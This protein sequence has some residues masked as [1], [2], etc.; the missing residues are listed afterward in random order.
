[1]KHVVSFNINKEEFDR[2]NRLLAIPS[3]SEMSDRDLIAAGANTDQ[4][5]GVLYVA[6]DDGS[7]L[8][9]DLCS[10]QE[11]YFDDVVWT[12]PDGRLDVCLECAFELSDIEFE[13]MGEEYV[14]KLNII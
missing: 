2:I 8:N 6:F 7:S 11:N 5:E 9:Y 12:S 1:M 14:V 3:L 13:Y 10:G 4:C